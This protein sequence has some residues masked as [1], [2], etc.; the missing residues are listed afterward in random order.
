MIRVRLGKYLRDTIYYAEKT[1]CGEISISG[2]CHPFRISKY[3]FSDQNRTFSIIF[4]T[5][6]IYIDNERGPY[7]VLF[8][9]YFI[10]FFFTP[11]ISRIGSP[12]GRRSRLNY[13]RIIQGSSNLNFRLNFDQISNGITAFARLKHF[14]NGSPGRSFGANLYPTKPLSFMS[15]CISI[16]TFYGPF[17]NNDYGKFS[18]T[19]ILMD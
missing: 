12:F 6:Y 13:P 19:S 5:H 2:R 11:I 7:V 1:A 14:R 18:P 15:L 9:E 4:Y 16:N 17:R 10:E 3:C 8:H